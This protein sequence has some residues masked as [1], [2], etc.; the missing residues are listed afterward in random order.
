M[1]NRVISGIFDPI[2]GQTRIFP[3]YSLLCQFEVL[4]DQQLHTKYQKNVMNQ[5][6]EIYIAM[7]NGAISGICGPIFGQKRIFPN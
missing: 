6:R 1:E 4:I 7:E 5:S 3:N 2:F